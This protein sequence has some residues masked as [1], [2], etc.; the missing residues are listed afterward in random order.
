MGWPLVPYDWWAYKKQKFG[1]RE[2]HAHRENVMRGAT[3]QGHQK[4]EKGPGTDPPY[5]RQRGHG[6]ASTAP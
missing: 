4:L 6:R 3:C 2:R 5:S 1:Q